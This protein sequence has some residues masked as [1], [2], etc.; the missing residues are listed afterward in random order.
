MPDE[1]NAS[2]RVALNADVVGYSRLLADDFETTT[3]T[4][5][6]Y[7]RLVQRVVS[8]SGGT[9]VNFVG[10]NFMA[11]FDEAIEGVKAAIAISTD[12][13]KRNA[14]IPEQRQTWFRMGMDQGEVIAGE[15]QHF[16]DALNI[17][18]R[19]QAIAP[20]GGL[21]ISG[22]VYRALDEPALRFRA[23]GRRR[24]KNIPE[25]VEVYE[26]LDLPSNRAQHSEPSS[27]SLEPPTVAVLPFHTDQ[28]KEPL[29]SAVAMIRSDLIHRLSRVPQLRV[30]DA[31]ASPGDVTLEAP[32]RYSVEAGIHQAGDKANLFLSLGDATTWNVVKSHKWSARVDELASLS[33][34]IADEV[35][36]SIEVELIIGEPAGIYAELDDA[37]AMEKIYR[38]WYELGKGTPEGWFRAVE[39]FEE[40]ARSHPDKPFGHVLGAFANLVGYSS[41]Q[42]GDP[43]RLLEEA[44]QKAQAALSTD[45][46]TGIAQMVRAA[47]LMTQ[48]KGEEAMETI[49]GVEIVRPTCDITFGLEGSIR[50][51][52]GQWEQAIDLVDHA[53][54][55]TG[56]NKPWY[57]TVKACS[58]FMGGK[59]E[60][61][62]SVAERVLEHQPNNL[63]ALLV[64]IG[65]Q[66]ELGLERRAKAN[67]ELVHERFASVDIAEWLEQNPYQDHAIIDRWKGDLEKAG[68]LTA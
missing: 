43:D 21:S 65:A 37:E 63:E 23:I 10:D 20:A 36:N 3:E 30:M 59:A 22:A 26:F 19:I 4:M 6:D 52:M 51:Y 61:A 54:R 58:L 29:Q 68:V 14:G 56:V 17:A 64:L 46:P 48:G 9:L 13:E 47:V 35:A 32:A 1:S 7:R 53:M 5:E 12:I 34:A 38:G 16:G 55:L 41:G 27:L 44:Y 28:L 31:Q 62:A 40:V 57:P 18:A 42:A 66:M 15:G 39:L 11:V 33:E 8:E 2:E 45:D 25:E 67:A 49:E 24:L 50:R 60:H